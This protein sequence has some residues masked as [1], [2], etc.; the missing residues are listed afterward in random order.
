M[1]IG[2]VFTV[3]LMLT[4]A[5]SRSIRSV[6]LRIPHGY[7]ADVESWRIGPE[8]RGKKVHLVPVPS[9]SAEKSPM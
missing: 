4:C 3:L 5:L 1:I 2:A 7:F 6:E 9:S 8:I